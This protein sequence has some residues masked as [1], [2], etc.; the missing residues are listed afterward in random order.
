LDREQPDIQWPSKTT[1]GKIFARNGL[2]IPRKYRRRFA[3]RS[4]PLSDSQ[5]CNDTWCLDFK[6]NFQ[7]RDNKK[8]DPFTLT[9]AFSRYL[10]AC[11]QLNKNDFEHVWAIF[12]IYFRE[13]GLPTRVR[14][15]NGPPFATT[16][17]GR[18]SRLSIHLIKAGV[19]PEWIEPGE[20][21]QNGRHER[22]HLTLKQEGIFPELSLE[23]QKIHFD[24][25]KEYYNFIRPHEAIGQKTPGEIYKPSLKIWSGRLKSPEYPDEYRIG[26]VKS[27]GKMS[28]Q[29]GEVYIGRV[30]EGEPVGLKENERGTL[31]AYYGPIFLGDIENNELKFQRRKTRK[32]KKKLHENVVVH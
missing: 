18:L 12:D 30:L 6:G 4:S 15:D 3:E 11:T 24:E 9:D 2:I 1:I 23:E 27:C 20:P 21:Q 26:K 28:W 8:C 14:S 25:F 19:I 29:G 22:M 17:P 31:T 7:T 32:G 16:S 13:Y 5:Q 10:L